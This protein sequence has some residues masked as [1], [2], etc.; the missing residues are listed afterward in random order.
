MS[1]LQRQENARIKAVREDLQFTQE[2]F[3]EI[4]EIS[5]SGYKK[6]ESGE[7]HLTVDKLYMLKEKLGLSADYVLFDEKGTIS[8]VWLEACKL[9][10]VEKWQMLM[11]LYAYL[12]RK[13][14]D[15]NVLKKLMEKIDKTVAEFWEN[16]NDGE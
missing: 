5:L 8:D 16:Y 13:T 4:F 1:K 3:A 9:P 6:I 11:R 12:S 10:P 2:Q 15:E 14:D 7:V